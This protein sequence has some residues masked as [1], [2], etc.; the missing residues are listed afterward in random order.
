MIE[1]SAIV[2]CFNAEQYLPDVLQ[3]IQNQS[4]PVSEIIV[5]DDGSSDNTSKMALDFGA[6]VYRH[7]HNFGLGSAR[8]SG[9]QMARYPLVAFIDSDVCITKT[10]LQ[11]LLPEMKSLNVAMA[12]GQLHELHQ[13]EPADKWRVLHMKQDNGPLRQEFHNSRVGRLAGFAFLG[14]KDAI[15]KIGLYNTQYGRS[16]EDV[17]ISHRLLKAGYILV[18]EPKAVAYHLRK[19]TSLSILKSSWSWDFW[20]YQ[21]AYTSL[22][23][24]IKKLRQNFRWTIQMGHQH[25][26]NGDSKLIYLDILMLLLFSIWDLRYWLYRKHK[27]FRQIFPLA[28]L[29]NLGTD[30]E[31]RK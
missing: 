10:W 30:H 16:Y 18:Y 24:L 26:G 31:T 29:G 13:R 27:V 7:E 3:A 19:D 6:R 4:V 21:G 11:N 28:P 9:I 12:G 15:R 14:K 23:G 22:A 5:I 8:N 1:V 2:P 17:D 25:L 20:P